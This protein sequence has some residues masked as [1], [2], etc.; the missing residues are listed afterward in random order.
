MSELWAIAIGL[1]FVTGLAGL[2]RVGA[3]P[4]PFDRM[5]AA[6]LLGTCLVAT[7]LLGAHAWDAA[8]LRDVALLVALLAAVAALAMVKSHAGGPTR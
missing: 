8:P 1:V 7:L 6:Q 4:T 2:V 5:L 3:G